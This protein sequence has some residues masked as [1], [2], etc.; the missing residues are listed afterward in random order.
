MRELIIIAL[1]AVL[2]ASAGAFIAVSIKDAPVSPVE[3]VDAGNTDVTA[4]V[5]RIAVLE[6]R[7]T[8]DSNQRRAMVVPDTGVE[9]INE[10]DS[11]QVAQA[12]PIFDRGQR[13]EQR[14]QQRQQQIENQLRDAGW[15]DAEIDS[16][17]NLRVTAA[18]EME[19]QQYEAMRKALEENPDMMTPR[20]M[21]PRSAMRNALGDNKYEQYLEATGRPAAVTVSNVLSGSAGDAAGLQPGDEIRRYGS[22]RVFHEGDLIIAILQGEPGESVTIEVERDG[23]V[24]HMTVPRGPL[25]TSRGMGG[26]Y[27]ADF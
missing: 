13:F 2:S 23:T 10:S 11:A 7:I 9:L 18:I 16:L 19:Q 15:T 27:I 1:T 5:Q 12:A 24:F 3:N 20:R 8:A 22:E 26:R 6:Q 25:G 17:E 4:L 14:V 21:D